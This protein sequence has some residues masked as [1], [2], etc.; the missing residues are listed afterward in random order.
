MSVVDAPIVLAEVVEPDLLGELCTGHAQHHGIGIKVF[1]AGHKQVLDVGQGGE[2]LRWLFGFAKARKIFTNFAT[3]IKNTDPEI[4]EWQVRDDPVTGMRFQLLAISYEFDVLGKLVFGPYI[5]GEAR[6]RAVPTGVPNEPEHVHRYQQLCDA[7]PRFS[8]QDA[9]RRMR[10]LLSSI[11][12]IAHAGYKA[13]CTSN[14]H[15]ES[16]TEAYNDLEAANAELGQKNA[17]LQ[18]TNVRLR[19]LDDL[20]SNF[21]STVSHE[22]RTPLTSVI[23]Y[24][25]M[26]LEDLAGPLNEEQREYISTIRERGESLL[27]LI[28]SILDISKIE[29]GN[30]TLHLREVDPRLIVKDALSA[31]KPQARKGQVK[32][33]FDMPDDLPT[34]RVDLYKVRQ[35]LINLLGNAV[36]F[37]P[38]AGVVTVRLRYR[39]STQGETSSIVRFQVRDTGIGIPDAEQKKIFDAFYQVDNTSTREYGGT[40]L[41]LS[42]VK[43]FVEAHGGRVFVKSRTGEGSIFSFDIPLPEESS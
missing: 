37:T 9:R 33:K 43:S 17:H 3:S 22:L 21:L 15:L 27:E 6:P 32:L 39:P 23:G 35:S 19:E 2:L 4:G 13:L 40:G 42:I 20:K 7:L 8:D 26:L 24:S 12:I 36:K 31:V 5:N 18:S 25:E 14:M 10:L 11:D 28:S 1:D 16:I 34:F 30:Q 38:P 41:G 29:S